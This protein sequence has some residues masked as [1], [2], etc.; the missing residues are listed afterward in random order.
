MSLSNESL[1]PESISEALGISL[2]EVIGLYFR[3]IDEGQRDCLVWD[4][5]DQRRMN[6]EDKVNR[7]REMDVEHPYQRDDTF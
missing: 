1:L 5:I 7:V 4:M 3:D 2:S 6:E